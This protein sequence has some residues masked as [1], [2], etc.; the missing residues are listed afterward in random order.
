MSTDRSSLNPSQREAALRDMS[1]RE[2]DLVVIGG[3]VT[4][5]GTAL[6]AVSRGLSVA[7]LEAGDLAEGTSS[8]S[9]KV[10][11][12][13]LRYLEQLN[14]SLVKEALTE[15]D[16]MVDRLCPHLV[17]PERF[18]FPFTRRRQRPY[19]GAGVLLYDL[20]RLTGTRSVA[21]HRHLS[22]AAV[23]RE[24]PALDPE[25][26]TGGVQYHDVRVDDARHTMMVARTAARVGARIATR[27]RVVGMLVEGGRVRGVRVRD[28][29]GGTELTVRARAVVNAAGVWAEA[30][31][32]LAGES[33]IAVTAAKGIHL[34]VPGEVINSRTGLI[35]KTA[36]SV[37][38]IRR[39]FDHWLLG[40]TDTRWDHAR[41][42]P[43]A[44]RSDVDYLLDQANRWLRTPLSYDDVVGVYAGLRPLV[45]GKGSATA[46]LSRD[47]VVTERPRG[48]FT[49]VGGKYTTYRVMARDAV[50]AAARRLERPVP[51]SVT[52][53]L[54]IIGAAGYPALLNQRRT[55]AAE[56]GLDERRIDHLLG[57]YGALTTE[58]LDLIA[59]QPELGAPVAGAPGYLAAELHYAAAHEGADTLEDVLTRR[60]RVFMETPDRGG[61]AATHAADVVGDV[62]GWD[63]ARRKD[64][65]EA[66]RVARSAE[67]RGTQA[68]S[69]AE[70]VAALRAA[71]AE[72]P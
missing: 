71:L 63:D 21:G 67:R 68:R 34:V 15:R 72:R 41:S 57:R 65:V 1:Q 8:R 10:F 33:S 5:V 52:D 24:M 45:S 64:E 35:A 55:L 25:P 20:L 66:Y 19:V 12:G 36:D 30:V 16:L 48:L 7:L 37:F 56:A 32:E 59:R 29:R 27:A 6:D 22:R 17:S 50:D 14:F 49:V 13:G 46:S 38:I 42:Q 28:E 54:P 11:H 53:R 2:F 9:G 47:H 70:A 69:D 26:I 51:H 62:L 39:W 40:T 31:Q 60:T 44:T 43:V 3:G 61:A 23:L 58:L 4:G 18:L